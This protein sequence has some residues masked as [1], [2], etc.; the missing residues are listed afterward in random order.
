MR[1]KAVGQ[2]EAIYGGSIVLMVVMAAVTWRDTAAA[3]G[4]GVAVGLNA[5]VVGVT[6]LVLLLATRARSRVALWLLVALTVLGVG[7]FLWQVASG[8]LSTGLLGVLTSVQTVMAVIAVVL[9]F[10]PAAR[11]WFAHEAAPPSEDLA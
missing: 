9:L 5:G 7:G 6:L 4:E 1:A 2:A 10:R 8:V 11:A 3:Y